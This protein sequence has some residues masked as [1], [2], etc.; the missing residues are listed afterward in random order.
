MPPLTG[1]IAWITG[2]GTGIGRATTLAL[3]AAGAKV[4][5]TGRTLATLEETAAL[6]RAD[7]GIALIAQADVTDPDAVAAAHEV[8]VTRLGD[9]HILVNNAGWNETKRHWKDLTPESVQRL[10]AGNLTAPFLVTLTVLPAMRARRDGVLIHIASIS[11]TTVFLPSGPVYT[12]AKYGARAMSQTLNAEE[13]IHGIRSIC[14]N[15]GEVVTPILD[16]RPTKPTP[17]QLSLMLHAED[18]A[19]A[20]L[21]CATLPPRAVVTDLTLMPTDASNWR[22]DATAIAART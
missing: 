8:V 6:V 20:V 21:F 7:G 14:I 18:I 2:A 10:V 15:P 1:K 12:A 22:A 19:A 13:G 3:A 17:E 16:K 4:A 9:P 11:A 5:L